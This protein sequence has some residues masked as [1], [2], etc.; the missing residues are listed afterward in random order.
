MDKPLDLTRCGLCT[1][2]LPIS[3]AGRRLISNQTMA[4]NCR[5]CSAPVLDPPAPSAK[6][7]VPPMVVREISVSDFRKS[8]AEGLNIVR[9]RP[10]EMIIITKNGAYCA[11]LVSIEQ[12][13]LLIT[14]RADIDEFISSK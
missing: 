1:A 13:K 4:A 11:A 8:L 10:D 6:P 9:Y 7:E 3:A 14:S 2:R 12:L 5:R